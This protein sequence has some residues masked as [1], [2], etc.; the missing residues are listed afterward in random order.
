[1]VLTLRGFAQVSYSSNYPKK[2][3]ILFQFLFQK[4]FWTFW[5]V[6]KCPAQIRAMLGPLKLSTKSLN[7]SFDTHIVS[8][9]CMI[10]PP[11][12]KIHR[13]STYAA[14]CP[15][16]LDIGRIRSKTCSIKNPS[17]T[18]CRSHSQTIKPSAG[19][20]YDFQ[21]FRCFEYIYCAIKYF[22]LLYGCF[23]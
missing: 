5:P 13:K 20:E 3:V 23:T 12:P 10:Y 6:S 2:V 11:D 17:I 7:L 14:L 1:M 22:C 15:T 18:D 19:S 4:K 9:W 16:P 21:T 8:L